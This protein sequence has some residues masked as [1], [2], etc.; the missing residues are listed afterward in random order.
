MGDKANF[1]NRHKAARH[2][3]MQPSEFALPDDVKRRRGPEAE[4]D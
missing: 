4:G 1:D 3:D 2:P